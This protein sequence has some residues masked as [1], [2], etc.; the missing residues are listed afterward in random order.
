VRPRVL[1]V[2]RSRYRLPLEGGLA[3]KFDALAGELDVRVLASGTGGDETFGLVPP[4]PPLDG[5]RFWV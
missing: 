4:R 5:A 2:G 3:R 1:I